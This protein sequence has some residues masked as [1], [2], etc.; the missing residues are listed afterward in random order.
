MI[1]YIVRRQRAIYNGLI[2]FQT[3]DTEQ[4]VGNQ[5]T[6]LAIIAPTK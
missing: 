6:L 4:S 5:I 1:E 2:S 3:R